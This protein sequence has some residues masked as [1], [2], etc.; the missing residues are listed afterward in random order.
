MF[1]VQSSGT[2]QGRSCSYISGL[3]D[4]LGSQTQTLAN[5][6]ARCEGAHRGAEARMSRCVLG[7]S[8][9]GQVGRVSSVPG[10]ES[11]AEWV[12]Q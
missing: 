6:G 10:Q 9:D 5:K 8:S 12:K 2:S 7:P 4:V 1:T 3:T 11:P